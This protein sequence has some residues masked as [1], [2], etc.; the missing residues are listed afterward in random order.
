VNHESDAQP[1]SPSKSLARYTFGTQAVTNHAAFAGGA[2]YRASAGL[3]AGW[4][5]ENIT[6]HAPEQA[7][8]GVSR[9]RGRLP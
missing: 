1:F 9:R 6:S 3:M 2:E 8:D 4:V 5:C 7:G